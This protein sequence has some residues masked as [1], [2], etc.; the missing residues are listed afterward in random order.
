[1]HDCM[2]SIFHHYTYGHGLC[3]HTYMHACTT[4]HELPDFWHVIIILDLIASNHIWCMDGTGHMI[5]GYIDRMVPAVE[6]LRMG[7]LVQAYNYV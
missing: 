4:H 6:S 1:M 2:S 7:Q 3:K 5:Q